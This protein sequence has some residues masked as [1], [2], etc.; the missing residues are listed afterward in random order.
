MNLE[1][2]ISFLQ[3]LEG[4]ELTSRQGSV[5]ELFQTINGREER[6]RCAESDLCR[7]ARAVG[8]EVRQRV[9]GSNDPFLIMGEVRD[10]DLRRVAITAGV[11]LVFASYKKWRAPMFEGVD[12]TGVDLSRA[13]IRG[14]AGHRIGLAADFR[15][16]CPLSALQVRDP[17][18]GSS[19]INVGA[20]DLVR[21]Q[22]DADQVETIVV[23]I[24]GGYAPPTSVE[25]VRNPA[26]TAEQIE[27]ATSGAAR[28]CLPNIR[29]NL[30]C[31]PN[32]P[33][34]RAREIVEGIPKKEVGDYLRE[35]DLRPA[36]R[37]ML[38][39]RK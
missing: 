16:A 5:V 33:E 34:V 1:S 14:Q 21:C 11:P 19:G 7:L 17:E 3:Q 13:H 12:L 24:E 26:C 8:F 30:L 28:S 39:R 23:L 27:R 31:S 15:G 29:L 18:T 4:C 32:L 37:E 22:F 25:I 2:L 35:V 38:I 9:P 10:L 36:A 6:A 20:L